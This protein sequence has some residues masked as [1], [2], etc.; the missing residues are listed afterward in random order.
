MGGV[1]VHGVAATWGLVL[2]EAQSERTTSILITGE[3]FDCG[4][5]ILGRVETNNTSSTRS[6]VRLILN[7]GLLDLSDSGEEFDKILVASR[8]WKLLHVSPE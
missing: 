4:V 1:S 8:P 2:D 5:G 6:S 3:F 7:F